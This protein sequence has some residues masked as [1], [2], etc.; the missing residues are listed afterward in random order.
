[1]LGAFVVVFFGLLADGLRCDDNCSIAPGW[2]NDP[3]AWQW[4]AVLVL[5][6]VVLGSALV[7]SVSALMRHGRGL[8][9]VAVS[10]QLAAVVFLAILS[11]TASETQG[12]SGYLALLFVF[13]SA[14]GAGLVRSTPR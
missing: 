2:R 11:L 9:V 3:N 8:G 7:L 4:Q 12:G 6:L 13:F 10:V 1:L 14:T 5:A